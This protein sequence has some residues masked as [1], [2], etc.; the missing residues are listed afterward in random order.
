MFGK[1]R[2]IRFV[3][4]KTSSENNIRCYILTGKETDLHY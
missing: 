3:V 4:E 1:L 2:D